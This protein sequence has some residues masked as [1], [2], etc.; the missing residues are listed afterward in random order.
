MLSVVQA[1]TYDEWGAFQWA[2]ELG[3]L[4]NESALSNDY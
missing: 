4:Q 2:E 1:N 3:E